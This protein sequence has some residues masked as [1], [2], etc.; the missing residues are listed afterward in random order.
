LKSYVILP[1]IQS[2]VNCFFGFITPKNYIIAII[3]YGIS[4]KAAQSIKKE[5][6][7]VYDILL[8]SVYT[9]E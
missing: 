1:Q 3:L 4:P 9:T 7:T 5:Q 2:K 8:F 6:H